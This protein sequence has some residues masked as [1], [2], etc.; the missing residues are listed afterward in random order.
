MQPAGPVKG[1]GVISAGFL[2]DP[3]R[4]Q[5]HDTPRVQGMASLDE[6]YNSSANVADAGAVYGY[7]A[8][9][10]HGHSA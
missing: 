5:W 4:P 7:S 1:V 8:A 2:K 10:T 9:Q 3:T 6:K